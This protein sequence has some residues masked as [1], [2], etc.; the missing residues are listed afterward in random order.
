MVW[1]TGLYLEAVHGGWPHR[2]LH[3]PVPQVVSFKRQD[4]LPLQERRRPAP[5]FGTGR[6]LWPAVVL[7]R[8]AIAP[9][10]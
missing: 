8:G 4:L 3:G 1:P 2:I 10:T 9:G 6:L 5:S 7:L